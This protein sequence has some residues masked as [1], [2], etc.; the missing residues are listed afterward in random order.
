MRLICGLYRLDGE[1]VVPGTIGAMAAGMVAAPLRPVTR[2]WAEGSAG[3]AVVDFAPTATRGPLAGPGA[4]QVLAA[5][6]RLDAP[7]ELAALLGAPG[8]N[9]DDLLAA[10]LSRWG[11]DAPRHLLG[12]FAIAQWEPATGRLLCARDIFGVRPFHYV[13]QPGKLFGF[14]SFPAGLHAAGLV[15]R[16][17]ERMALARHLVQRQRPDETLFV[18]VSR[19]PAAH[20]L[21]VTPAGLSLR[22]YWAPDARAAG[23]L[24]ATPEAAAAEMRR[25]VEAAVRSRLP[26]TGPVGTHL[27]GGLDSSAIAVLAARAL[28]DRGGTLRAWSFLDVQ[29]NDIALEDETAFVQSVLDQEPDIAWAPVRPARDDV[30]AGPYH[31]DVPL[32]L[33]PEEPESAVCADAAAAGVQVIL[34]GWGGDEAATF[35]GRGALAEH[36][37]RGRWR[38]L[39]RE[40]SALKRARGASAAALLRGEILAFLAPVALHAAFAR[41]RGAGLQDR[42]VSCLSPDLVAGLQADAAGMLLMAP[43]ARTNRVRLIGSPHIAQRC[44]NWAAQGA[45]HGIAF[46]FPMLDRRVVDYALSLPSDLFLRGGWRRRVFRDAMQGIL[47]EAIRGHHG[48][49]TPFPGVS[50]IMAEQRDKLAGRLDAFAADATVRDLFD[51]DA[52]HAR[53]AALPDPEALKPA[54][55][56]NARPTPDTPVLRH[57]LRLAAYLAQKPGL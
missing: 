9:D 22:R 18:G 27:S 24:K 8:V 44:E 47:P 5:D 16:G 37:L 40:F 38:M 49:S 54:L 56:G 14:A 11:S 33:G 6:V 3:L 51:L 41:R 36:L 10:A 19:L 7:E 21:E 1:A 26:R 34:C 12:D 35:N 48:K 20:M 4:G 30:D 25:L 55:S 28:R 29:R 57:A 23:R 45:R 32:P 43:D 31:S 50:L 52:L 46:A 13:W 2:C 39:A 53:I 42:L 15:A 17:F